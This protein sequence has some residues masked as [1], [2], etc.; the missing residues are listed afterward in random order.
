VV[1]EFRWNWVLNTAALALVGGLVVY[2]AYHDKFVGTWPEMLTI[3]LAAFFADLS[4]D[5]IKAKLGSA[6]GK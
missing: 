3:F 5:A 6:G 4:W 2:L 1:R